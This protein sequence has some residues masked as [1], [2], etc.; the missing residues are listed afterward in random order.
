M[1]DTKWTVD[2]ENQTVESSDGWKFKFTHD[3]AHSA[4]DGKCVRYPELEVSEL[5]RV[6]AMKARQAGDAF[7]E[8]LGR[9]S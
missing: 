5:A 3:K 9:A 7:R 1:K 4:W 2:L 8:A 6:S